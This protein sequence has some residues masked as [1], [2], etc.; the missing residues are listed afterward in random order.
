MPARTEAEIAKPGMATQIALVSLTGFRS[1]IISR[2][3][4]PSGSTEVL[5]GVKLDFYLF[6]ISPLSRL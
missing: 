1:R 5:Q 6:E 3:V 2:Y 4:A